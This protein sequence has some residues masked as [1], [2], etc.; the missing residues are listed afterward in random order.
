MKIDLLDQYE[1]QVEVEYKGDR[2]LA[3]DNGAVCRKSRPGQ[4]KR[5]LDG[6]WTFGRPD[7]S[8]GYMYVG[9]HVVHRVVA[10]AFHGDRPSAK[11]I[12]DHIDTNRRNNRAE[13]VRWITRL[14]NVLLNPITRKRI[15][16]AYGSPDEFFKNPGAPRKLEPN[17][18]WMRTVSKEEAEESRKRLLQWAGSDQLPKGGQLG[19][20]VYGARQTDGPVLEVIPDKQSLTPMA[21]Q[22]HWKT[23]SEFPICPDSIGSDPLSEYAARLKFGTVFTRNAFGAASTV[24]AKQ[25][26]ALLTVLCRLP[27]NSVKAWALTKVT[28]ENE[29][30][31]HEAMGTYF[32][33]QGALKAHCKLID[34]SF[35]ESIDDY[36]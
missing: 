25:G 21:I 14:D 4:P 12:V 26:D 2:Y 6:V 7:D 36:S 11:H 30:F 10:V 18:D 32:T 35:E 27:E 17:F 20:W 31:V 5:K 19:D 23:P 22:R 3:R 1:R 8:T 24:V 13:N 15:E 9:S 28:V 33:L 34:V 16:V 29:K